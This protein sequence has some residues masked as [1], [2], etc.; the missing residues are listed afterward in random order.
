MRVYLLSA[1]CPALALLA[2]AC[3]PSETTTAETEPAAAP[4]AA[5]DATPETPPAAEA[6]APAQQAAATPPPAQ[7]AAAAS[8][9]PD[10]ALAA[11]ELRQAPMKLLSWSFGPVGGMLRGSVDFD[12]AVVERNTAR[13]AHA[14]SYIPALFETDTSGSDV[15]TRA[16]PSIWANKADFDMK[17]QALIDAATAAS[18]AAATGDQAATMAAVGAMGQTCGGCHDDY[19]SN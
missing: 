3:G 17:A 11:V 6:P 8:D 9:E 5:P 1:V 13:M 10:A 4:A 19:R 2:T 14:A 16:L 15:E 18:A 7:P 12:A